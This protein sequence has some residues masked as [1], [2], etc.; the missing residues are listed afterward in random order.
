MDERRSHPRYQLAPPLRG[1]AFI[2]AIGQF[3]AQLL[4]V[5]V[6]G[7]RMTLELKSPDDLVRFLAAREKGITGAFARP[8]GPPWKFVMLHT[9]RT[10][11]NADGSAGAACVIAGRFVEV[12]NFTVADLER[13]VAECLAVRT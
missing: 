3:D 4:D 7:A 10:T 8:E 2:D 9:R 5:S 11:L 12:P 6:D 13:L 1:R